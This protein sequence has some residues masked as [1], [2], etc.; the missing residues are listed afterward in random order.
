[1]FVFYFV[2]TAWA[3]SRITMFFR[4]RSRSPSALT[5]SPSQ[6]PNA[7][8]PVG[9]GSPRKH[10]GLCLL[11]CP[12]EHNAR[13]RVRADAREA[14]APSEAGQQTVHLPA[15]Q[16]GHCELLRADRPVARAAAARRQ[17]VSSVCALHRSHRCIRSLV[18]IDPLFR[19]RSV[20]FRLQFS[21]PFS[22]CF[23]LFILYSYL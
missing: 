3:I 22:S 10:T 15:R 11:S 8:P 20:P 2:G 16:T 19:F 21:D 18:L 6:I 23:D 9:A 12:L 1:M 5:A 13:R 14:R 7:R 17:A 4:E